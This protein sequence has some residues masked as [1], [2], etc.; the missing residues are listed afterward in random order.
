MFL[1]KFSGI[2]ACQAL[3]KNASFKLFTK[4]WFCPWGSLAHRLPLH[5]DGW[6]ALGST[7]HRGWACQGE[8]CTRPLQICERCQKTLVF[9][10]I[11][12]LPHYFFSHNNNID[13]SLG[14][15]FYLIFIQLQGDSIYILLLI[16]L[17]Y[18]EDS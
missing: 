10:L 3:D 12:L 14:F 16:S 17:K 5:T 9:C 1:I 15:L 8:C 11:L 7:E 4:Y 6:A 18:L 13:S 2:N